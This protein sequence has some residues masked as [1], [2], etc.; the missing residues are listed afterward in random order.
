V[1]PDDIRALLESI[2]MGRTGVQ[3]AMAKLAVL[4][5]EDLGFAR[6]DHHRAL[7]TGFPE[8]V[9]GPDKRAE[10]IA[11]IAASIFARRQTAIV[12]RI[13]EEHAKAVLTHLSAIDPEA[14]NAAAYEPEPHFLV[15]GSPMEKRGRGAIAV[16]SAGTSDRRVAEEAARTAELF[17]N[18]VVRVRDVGVAGL[19]RLIAQRPALE[20]AEVIIAVAGMEGAL[21]SV[22]SGLVSRPIIAVPTS[23]GFGASFGGLAALLAMLNSCAPGVT[24][25]NIDAGFSA[26]YA[27]SL[28]NLVR[29]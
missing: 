23:V 7:R 29:R 8:V 11:E 14:A 13:E 26:G 18:E 24:V 5:Y 15:A 25:V 10:E 20:S 6:V 4:P 17:G 9:Y 3:D 27:A 21:A 2:A 28:M 12:T 22:V 16:V 19:H 1:K